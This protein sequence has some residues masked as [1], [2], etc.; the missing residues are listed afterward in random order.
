[1]TPQRF[2][3]VFDT[4]AEAPGGIERLREL[5]LQL[6][7]RGKLVPQDDKDEPTTTLLARISTDE[8]LVSQKLQSPVE[9][10]DVPWR[11]PSTWTWIRLKQIVNF[12]MGKTPPTKDASYWSDEAGGYP[13]VSITD[14]DHF[15]IVSATKRHVT[16]KAASEVFGYRPVPSGTIL[17][18]FKLTIGKISRLGVDAYH[19]EAIIALYPIVDEMD[20]YLFQFMPLFASGGSSRDAIKG[21]TL[22]SDSLSNLLVA[23]PPLTEQHRIV[24]KVNELMELIDRL[25][26]HLITK[27]EH[28]EAFA[29]AVT[30]CKAMD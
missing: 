5:V 8:R 10:T 15:R 13:W 20:A 19:N 7:V 14:M 23:L 18:S 4:I 11:L 29:V 25:E 24:A 17:M 27:R 16:N 21:K 6:A 26:Q 28:H 12:T 3:E 1:M 9:K 2:I 30:Q 22:N